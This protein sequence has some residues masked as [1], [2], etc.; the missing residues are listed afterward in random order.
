M[1][2]DRGFDL[3]AAAPEHHVRGADLLREDLDLLRAQH[4]HVG[5]LRV[6]HGDARHA[7]IRAHDHGLA[8]LQPSERTTSSAVA[9]DWSSI[10]PRE[11]VGTSSRARRR[12]RRRTPR[13][14]AN[15]V[16]RRSPRWATPRTGGLGGAPGF[17]WSCRGLREGWEWRERG[18]RA[19]NQKLCTET[20]EPLM[21]STFAPGARRTGR[22]TATAGLRCV[23]QH[24]SDATRVST[25]S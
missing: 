15:T 21:T 6:A 9:A 22:D 18:C 13:R 24:V 2:V 19:V 17:P 5:D 25:T 16:R 3:A 20:C 7:V 14:R 10:M 12:S 23:A 8:L 11:P 4:D 1:K